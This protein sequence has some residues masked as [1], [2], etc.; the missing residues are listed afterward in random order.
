VLVLVSP[1]NALIRSS[2]RGRCC[3]CRCSVGLVRKPAAPACWSRP[4]A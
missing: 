1:S 2:R 3:S 4:S